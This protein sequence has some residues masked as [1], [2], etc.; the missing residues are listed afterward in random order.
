MLRVVTLIFFTT[1]LIYGALPS[2]GG[3]DLNSSNA[4]TVYGSGSEA[5]AAYFEADNN[6]A[7]YLISEDE[8]N[9]YKYAWQHQADWPEHGGK[10]PLDKASLAGTIY[11]GSAGVYHVEYHGNGVA[12]FIPSDP[13]K[14]V[15]KFYRV[16]A[17]YEP[18]Y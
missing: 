17:I 8:F 14:D 5:A 9:A 1:S 2:D 6:P 16:A 10:I 13:E 7:D 3:N 4:G 11:F 18:G 12:Q 15:T